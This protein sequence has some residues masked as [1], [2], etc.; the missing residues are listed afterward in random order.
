MEIL[1]LINEEE[2]MTELDY[3]HFETLNEL[4][5]LRKRSSMLLCSQKDR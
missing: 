4:I 2:G 3:H 5:N 1:Q